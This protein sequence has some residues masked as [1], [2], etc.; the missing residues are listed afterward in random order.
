MLPSSDLFTVDSLPLPT[1]VETVV[2][3]Y[4]T[5]QEIKDSHQPAASDL[6]YKNILMIVSDACIIIVS[7]SLCYC[8]QLQA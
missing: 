8:H 4:N 5:D 7:P 2:E 6:Y 3:Y 1:T